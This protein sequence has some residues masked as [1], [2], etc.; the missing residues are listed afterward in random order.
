MLIRNQDENGITTY[1]VCNDAGSC[2]LYTTDGY[3]AH[4]IHYLS[5][6][7]DP[8]LRLTVGGDPG[9]RQARHPVFHHVRRYSR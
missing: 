4:L 6:G 8:A 9:T 5:R 7:I 2:L 3:M 1:M